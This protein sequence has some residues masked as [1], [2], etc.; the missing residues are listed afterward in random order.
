MLRHRLT[1][2]VIA[3]LLSACATNIVQHTFQFNAGLDSPDAEVLD[4]RYGQSKQPGVRPP[5]WAYKVNK[6]PQG[7]ATGGEMLKGDELYVKWR[8]RSTG[9][10][11]EDTVDLRRRFPADIKNHT[12]YFIIKGPQLYVY[13][14]TPERAPVGSPSDGPR[15]YRHMKT[16]TIYPGSS[17]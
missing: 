3:L 16:L 17:K 12:V 13:L 1:S 4:F 2:I 9:Q 10:V 14:V 7:A 11:F 15:M 6:I 5:E 8:L